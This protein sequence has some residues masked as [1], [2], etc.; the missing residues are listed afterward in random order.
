[1]HTESNVIGLSD[2]EHETVQEWFQEL[3]G[4]CAASREVVLVSRLAGA[5]TG[6]MGIDKEVLRSALLFEYQRKRKLTGQ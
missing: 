4:P 3:D 6:F 2:A 5:L 1:M